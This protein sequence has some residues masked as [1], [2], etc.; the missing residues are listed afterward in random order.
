MHRYTE[1]DAFCGIVSMIV[2]AGGEFRSKPK[3]QDPGE[4][5]VYVLSPSPNM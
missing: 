4:P 3:A 5:M 2:E 1:G